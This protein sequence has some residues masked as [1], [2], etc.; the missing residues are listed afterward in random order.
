MDKVRDF[1]YEDKEIKKRV[2]KAPVD[3]RP[4][5][6]DEHNANNAPGNGDFLAAEKKPNHK[7]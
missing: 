4:L 5:P 7:K 3:A 2:E 1:F 6:G